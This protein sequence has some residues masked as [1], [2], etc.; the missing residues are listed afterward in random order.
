MVKIGDRLM[1][2][3]NI[4]EKFTA[5]AI[6]LLVVL[7][8]SLPF[9]SLWGFNYEWQISV[10]IIFFIV[11]SFFFIFGHDI[12]LGMRIVGSKW[13]G[14]YSLR[15]HFVYTFLYTLSFATLFIHIWFPFDL[16][17]IN[18]LCIQLPTVLLT[19]TTFHGYL[20]GLETVK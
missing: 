5:S 12:D 3:T 18:M 8:L 15:R 7:F 13:K 10:V 11:E 17:I 6:N 20:S 9:Y 2:H 4:W 19:G 14:R 1:R 16:F